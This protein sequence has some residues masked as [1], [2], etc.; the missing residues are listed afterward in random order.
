MLRASYSSDVKRL[1]ASYPDRFAHVAIAAAELAAAQD[2]ATSA[3]PGGVP[4]YTMGT[5]SLQPRAIVAGVRTVCVRDVAL[6]RGVDAASATS[7]A[8]LC[9]AL[10]VRS[11]H[12]S[13]EPLPHCRP[14]C[15]CVPRVQVSLLL[16]YVHTDTSIV[17]VTGSSSIV[18]ILDYLLLLLWISYSSTSVQVH[19][20]CDVRRRIP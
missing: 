10:L 2:L 5:Q 6:S 9:R 1:L 20:M 15:V 11:L 4:G 12:L 7:L 16:G 8:S 14:H 19:S 17:M 13:L 18:S 3:G